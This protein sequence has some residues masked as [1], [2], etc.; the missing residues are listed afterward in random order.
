MKKTIAMALMVVATASFGDVRLIIVNVPSSPTPAGR[1]GLDK[2]KIRYLGSNGMAKRK[3]R[4][5]S[6]GFVVKKTES[7]E[8]DKKIDRN[9]RI[10]TL[11]KELSDVKKDIRILELETNLHCIKIQKRIDDLK[12]SNIHPNLKFGETLVLMNDLH[13][14]KFEDKRLSTLV[15]KRDSILHNLK[16]LKGER[17]KNELRKFHT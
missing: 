3:V 16:M 10:I 17:K 6:S 15:A 12:N 14:A 5:M 2:S 11:S 7:E 1:V 9:R 8:Q 4:P 13:R